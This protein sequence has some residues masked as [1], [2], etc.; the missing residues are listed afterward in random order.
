V[1]GGDGRR[2]RVEALFAEAIAAHEA[3]RTGDLAPIV[4]TVET[5]LAAFAR[6]GKVLVFGNG[7]SAADAQHLVAELVGRF[8]RDR[9]GV[10][11]VALTTD[12]SLLT[13]VAND[14][15]Y[16]RVFARQVEALGAPG[17]VALGISTSGRS[18]NV[19]AA[20][21]SARERGMTTIALTG[22]DGG[23]LGREADIHVHVAHAVTARVQEVQR[24]QMHAICELIEDAL[25]DGVAG[26]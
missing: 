21:A 20:F 4:R 13:A 6:G 23:T 18:A 24:T 9:R 11:A 10:A 3:A 22:G 15:G 12:T 7:G 14:Y 1:S 2:A 16:E 26:A 19:L 25:V 17:D 5:L 8:Q